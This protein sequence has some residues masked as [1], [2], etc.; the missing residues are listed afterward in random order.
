MTRDELL[1]KLKELR[2]LNVKDPEVSHARADEALLAYISDE[3][4]ARAFCDLERWYA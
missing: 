2:E 4:I 1:A 3:E